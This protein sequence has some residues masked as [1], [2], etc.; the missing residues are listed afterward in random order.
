STRRADTVVL[1]KTGTVTTGRMTLVEVHTA[2]GTTRADALRLA[3]AVEHA[4][5]HPIA[6]AIAEAAAAEAGAL[7]PVSGFASPA[8]LGVVGRVDGHEVVVGRPAFLAERGLTPDP[9]LAAALAEAEQ[10]GHTPLLAGWDGQVRAVLVVADQIKP[11][12]AE[13]V[14]QLRALGLTPVLLTGDNARTAHTVAE[15]VGI[16]QVP[17]EVLPADHV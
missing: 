17:A 15:A 13:A 1:D 11:T 3:G 6:R 4:S 9:D 14:A 7:P 10:A 16:E 5:E 2:T 8:G 12:S